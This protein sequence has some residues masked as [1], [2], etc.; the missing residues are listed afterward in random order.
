M[1]ARVDQ[2][3]D[4]SRYGEK[5]VAASGGVLDGG[6]AKSTLGSSH[7]QQTGKTRTLYWMPT[8]DCRHGDE[9]EFAYAPIPATVLDP[10]L[11]SGT[12]A[13]VAR[14]LGRNCVGFELNEDYRPLIDKRL[15]QGVLL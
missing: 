7:G 10:F 14:K 3:W 11:G 5:A 4:G 9:N 2:G 8:C 15:A 6:T 1:T 12:T 13:E